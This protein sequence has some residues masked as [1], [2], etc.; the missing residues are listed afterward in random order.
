MNYGY[1]PPPTYPPPR[2]YNTNQYQQMTY[3]PKYS[4]YDYNNT[5]NQYQQ[6]NRLTYAP[7][8]YSSSSYSP[9]YIDNSR[10]YTDNSK[11]WNYADMSKHYTDNTRNYD[12]TYAPVDHS[13]YYADNSKYYA[14]N[15]SRYF[16]QQIY[17][18]NSYRDNSSFVYAPHNTLIHD[19]YTRYSNSYTDNSSRSLHL[20]GANHQYHHVTAGAYGHPRPPHHGGHHG[21]GYGMGHPGGGY[22]GFDIKG[23]LNAVLPQGGHQPPAGFFESGGFASQFFNS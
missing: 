17:T 9:S 20:G 13:K 23:I 4:N 11:M 16:N 14:D 12:Y 22:G 19:P 15:S 10:Q 6:N 3:A 7:Q 21:G 1:A 18:D 8:S 5:V 2:T